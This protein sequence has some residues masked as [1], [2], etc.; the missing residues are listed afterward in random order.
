VICLERA[1]FALHLHALEPK[2]AAV[3]CGARHTLALTDRSMVLSFGDN[4]HGQCGYVP[5]QP[6]GSGSATGNSPVAANTTAKVSVVSETANGRQLRGAAI[7]CGYQH[8]FVISVSGEVYAFGDNAYGQLGLGDQR[9]RVG[10]HLVEGLLGIPVS[11]ISAGEFHSICVTVCGNVFVWG[12]NALGQ[13][14]AAEANAIVPAP[15]WMQYFIGMGVCQVRCGRHHTFV[16]TKDGAAYG[17]GDSSK[18]QLSQRSQSREISASYTCKKP[19]LLAGFPEGSRFCDISACDTGGVALVWDPHASRRQVWCW[20]E[21]VSESSFAQLVS[22]WTGPAVPPHSQQA[23]GGAGG[24][25]PAFSDNVSVWNDDKLSNPYLNNSDNNNNNSNQFPGAA[26]H[27]VHVAGA[28]PA[29][30]DFASA[31]QQLHLQQQQFRG[32]SGVSVAVGG[33]SGIICV[34]SD[35]A[36]LSSAEVGSMCALP[37]AP[38]AHFNREAGMRMISMAKAGRSSVK[39]LSEY[40]QYVLSHPA[41]MNASFL[42]RE[43]RFK[44]SGSI[45]GLE[46]DL[47]RGFLIEV[48]WGEGEVM[49]L[50]VLNII[51]TFK[52]VGGLS[53]Y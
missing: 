19:T 12:S 51:L 29:G 44:Q 46:M 41:C 42:G 52:R 26:I 17:F 43:A 34:M 32:L 33:G 40:L 20:G 48:S 5:P 11:H 1:F 16:L 53:P 8:S 50:F 4:S 49:Y 39:L 2:I 35:N 31:F 15:F 6:A 38:F 14:G 7:S 22:G 21:G 36:S 37:D 28:P 47:V 30:S 23:L 45:S 27:P 25:P 18:N 3:S 10:V 13:L 24:A 9:A